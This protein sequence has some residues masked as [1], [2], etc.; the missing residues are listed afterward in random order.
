MQKLDLTMKELV[1]AAHGMALEKG[2]W[3]EANDWATLRPETSQKIVIEKLCLVHS[4]ISEA[5]EALRDDQNELWVTSQGK[6]EGFPAELAD[7][8]IRIADLC[9]WMGIDLNDA[10]IRKMDYNKTRGYKHGRAF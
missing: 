4:E 3:D 5:L 2:F 1:H 9:G 7:A 8:V 10:I 6:P